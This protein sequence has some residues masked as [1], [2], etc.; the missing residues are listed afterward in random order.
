MC[1][2]ARARLEEE[3]PIPREGGGGSNRR[4]AF[5]DQPKVTWLTGLRARV[6]SSDFTPQEI[7]WFK[8][9]NSSL[10]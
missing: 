8:V 10:Y 2:C 3:N 5:Y 6:H 4:I 9:G 7:G 1:V